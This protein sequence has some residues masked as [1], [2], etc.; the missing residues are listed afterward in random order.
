MVIKAIV[1]EFTATGKPVGSQILDQKYNL[2]VSSATI[3]NEMVEL[4][5]KGYLV[6]SHVSSGRI[7][8]PTAI[9]F[10]VQELLKER[11]LSVAE[12]V[13]M[14][15]RVWDYRFN[16]ENLIRE[17]TRVLAERT[18]S[19]SIAALDSGAVYHAGYANLLNVEEF[20]DI[21]LFKQVLI[22]LDQQQRIMEIFDRAMGEGSIHLL[23]GDELGLAQGDQMSCLFADIQIGD[24]RGS[25][26]IIGP[27]RQQYDQNIPLVRYMANLINQVAQG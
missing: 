13:A 20:Y 15:E 1:E 12:E 18:R 16:V 4:M 10:Y 24:R 8:T 25:V 26:G 5:N 9:K 17:A 7:P 11:E 19:L 3:R 21:D 6:K 23:L 22:M 2:G 27:N 14:K